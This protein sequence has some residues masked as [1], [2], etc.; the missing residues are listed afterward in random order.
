VLA[1]M[2]AE[3]LDATRE[4]ERAACAELARAWAQEVEDGER[5]PRTAPYAAQQALRDFAAAIEARGRV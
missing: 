3:M 5:G 1:E 4:K 2:V